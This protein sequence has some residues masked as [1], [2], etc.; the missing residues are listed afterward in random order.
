MTAAELDSSSNGDLAERFDLT[1]GQVDRLRGAYALGFSFLASSRARA[2]VLRNAAASGIAKPLR[3]A[4]WNSI[5]TTEEE[6][7]R[8]KVRDAMSALRAEKEMLTF[9]MKDFRSRVHSMANLHFMGQ[10]TPLAITEHGEIM[11]SVPKLLGFTLMPDA[12]NVA[13]KKYYHAGV[14]LSGTLTDDVLNFVPATVVDAGGGAFDYVVQVLVDTGLFD[15]MFTMGSKGSPDRLLWINGVSDA[16]SDIQ[17]VWAFFA[18]FAAGS[19]PVPFPVNGAGAAPTRECLG[20][21]FFLTSMVCLMHQLDLVVKM[22]VKLAC[23]LNGQTKSKFR[24]DVTAV[25]SLEKMWGAFGWRRRFREWAETR[26]NSL[27]DCLSDLL[28]VQHDVQR[29]AESVLASRRK[30]KRRRATGAAGLGPAFWS[31]VEMLHVVLFMASRTSH[32]LKRLGR[33]WWSWGRKFHGIRGDEGWRE[34]PEGTLDL[35]GAVKSML[36][37]GGDTG[38]LALVAYAEIEVRICSK[39]VCERSGRAA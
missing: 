15:A 11:E 3:A 17:R 6:L 4:K 21:T 10:S 13:L 34:D 5:P 39:E 27:R 35:L 36:L 1:E 19:V 2:Q 16:G 30:Y 14:R 32:F 38:T 25:V 23:A 33:S 12:C 28:A 7:I 18:A 20:P 8:E 37:L 29:A 9:V 31:V 24:K 26:W 22:L